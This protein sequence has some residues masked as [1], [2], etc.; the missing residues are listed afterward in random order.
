[1]N[2]INPI[3]V[4]KSWRVDQSDNKSATLEVLVTEETT[5]VIRVNYRNQ[6]VWLQ[7]SLVIYNSQE[8]NKAT[9]TVPLWLFTRKFPKVP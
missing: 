5:K 1:M 2:W 9:I 6:T 7:K 4:Y 3:K 8:E